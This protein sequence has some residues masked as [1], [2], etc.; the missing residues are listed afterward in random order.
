[1]FPAAKQMEAKAFQSVL[2]HLTTEVFMLQGMF[3]ENWEWLN[4][5]HKNRLRVP[6]DQDA[7]ENIW[8]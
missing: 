2:Y 6:G 7:K 3:W 8:I 4:L 1:L 5:V